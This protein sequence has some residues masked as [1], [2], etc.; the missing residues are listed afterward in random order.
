MQSMSSGALI[1]VSSY[2]HHNISDVLANILNIGQQWESL[3]GLI[4]QVISAM[5][6]FWRIPTLL[7]SDAWHHIW[8]RYTTSQALSTFK[9]SKNF[10]A[11]MSMCT[12]HVGHCEV[13]VHSPPRK[14]VLFDSGISSLFITAPTKLSELYYTFLVEL[15]TFIILELSYF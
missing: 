6:F 1:F 5:S 4:L 15:L 12:S 14:P 9:P 2:V 3:I 11:G 13:G 7:G 10:V 8:R